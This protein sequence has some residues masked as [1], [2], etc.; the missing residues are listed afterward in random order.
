MFNN[1]MIDTKIFSKHFKGHLQKALN[2]SGLDSNIAESLFMNDHSDI[3][4]GMDGQKMYQTVGSGKDATQIL[5]AELARQVQNQRNYNDAQ[6]MQRDGKAITRESLDQSFAGTYSSMPNLRNLQQ[7]YKDTMQAAAQEYGER[8][9]LH[10]QM[11][12]NFDKGSTQ[13]DMWNGIPGIGRSNLSAHQASGQPDQLSSQP[14]I[15]NP[16]I[17]KDTLSLSEAKDMVPKQTNAYGEAETVPGALRM[18]IE[19]NYSRLE[20][21]DQDGFY[22]EVGNLNAG[23]GNLT[24]DEQ[25]IQDMEFTPSGELT[26]LID[27]KTHQPTS[28]YRFVNGNQVPASIPGGL[29][30][31][32]GFFGET[33][34]STSITGYQNLPRSAK[35]VSSNNNG[36]Q[37]F[38]DAYQGQGYTDYD[39]RGDSNGLVV[40]GVNPGT[41]Q[42]E[43]LTNAYDYDNLHLNE[44]IAF[45]QPLRVLGNGLM[46][47]DHEEPQI[48]FNPSLYGENVKK[49]IGSNLVNKLNQNQDNLTDFLNGAMI[50]PTKPNNGN[51]KAN[52]APYQSMSNLDINRKY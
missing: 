35:L 46:N 1:S 29:P 50:L 20:A 33:G 4:A 3:V 40:T 16:F 28:P 7:D 21:M 9:V 22:H 30:D 42:R 13:G 39:L 19:N 31:I 52:H 14:P 44:G 15:E 24:A 27:S 12:S 18:V 6:I 48:T 37:P 25:V 23:D 5:D 26:P 17:T 8:A 51:Y 41:H 47:F 10:Q 2:G 32:N 38:L 45:V 43:V 49:T 36:T 34:Q 11:Q